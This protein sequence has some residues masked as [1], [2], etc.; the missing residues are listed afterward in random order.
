MSPSWIVATLVVV[1]FGISA[2][3]AGLTASAHR[4]ARLILLTAAAI[5]LYLCLLP[6]STQEGFAAGELVVLTPGATAT[7]LEAFSSASTIVALPDSGQ[8][9]DVESVPDLGTALRRHPDTHS[10]RIVGGGL[11]ARDRD[12]ARGRVA[13]FD[14]V[15]LPT[16]VVELV[17]PTLVRAGSTWRL[18]GRVEGIPQARLELRDPASTVVATVVVDDGGRFVVQVQSRATGRAL[19]SLRVLDAAGK[20]VEDVAVPLVTSEAEPVRVLLLAGAPDP[21]LKYFRRWASDAGIAIDSRVALTEGI[22]LT[23]GVAVLDAAALEKADVAIL[24][25][26]SW[27]ALDGARKALLLSAVDEG[28]GL[29]LRVTGP[30]DATVASEWAVLGFATHP[31]D[32]TTT[33]SLARELGIDVVAEGVETAAALRLVEA[34]GCRCVQGY[35]FSRPV[36]ADVAGEL[37]RRGVLGAQADVAAAPPLVPAGVRVA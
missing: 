36:P 11:P 3:R 19:F 1:A 20:R 15:P 7:Q 22:A 24:D 9:S 30:I 37:L 6:P 18:R 2:W 29:L 10:L 21:E 26:R 31:D 35:Y 4:R 16:G 8:R 27:A 33:V 23:E 14:A 32:A 5:L 12:V 34:A 25:E 17:L 13:R 28:L